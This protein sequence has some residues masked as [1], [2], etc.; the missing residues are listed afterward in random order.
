MIPVPQLSV[1]PAGVVTLADHE[2]HAQSVLDNNAWAYFSGGAADELTLRAN[3]NAWDTLQLQ[4]RVLRPLV[5]GHTRSRLLGHTL[6]H[7]MLL[8]P[9]GLPAHGA[10]RWGNGHRPR[11]GCARRR[12]GAE[13]PGQRGAGGGG[14]DGAERTHAR[15]AVVSALPATR[16]E[17]HPRTRLARA[18]HAGYEALV[19]TVDAPTHGARDRERRAGFRLP[20]GVS[21]V[22]L[23]GLP[24]SPALTLAAHQSALFDS[25]LCHAPTWDDL[26]WLR[27]VTRLP[28]VLKGVLH[29]N[30]AQQALQHG[31]SA[32]VVVQPRWPH[33]RHQPRDRCRAASHGGRVAR[34]IAFAGGRWHT[35]WHR[36]VEGHRSG[37]QRGHGRPPLCLWP[38]QCGNVGR[39]PC[40]SPAP[41]R[42][43]DCD[44]L[45]WLCHAG[46]CHAGGALDRQW[47]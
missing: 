42:T 7:P 24:P 12:F 13:H 27:G 28:I 44:G 29:P 30:D 23:A 5:G 46:R 21:A 35:A 39:R 9:F 2:R 15:A 31:V 45:V 16:P 20:A 10:P 4:P 37:R 17:F 34:R 3:R 6:Q 1:V 33:T 25:L 36:R 38:C 11:S 47:V 8:A 41:R 32:I 18:E 14:R 19:L 40:D 43:R 22:N 26:A